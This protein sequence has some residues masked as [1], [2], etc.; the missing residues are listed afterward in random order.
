MTGT[1]SAGTP[2]N[3][4]VDWGGI[5]P[6]VYGIMRVAGSSNTHNIDFCEFTT[7][8]NVR[9]LDPYGQNVTVVV[10]ALY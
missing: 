7:G 10:F 3:L 8:N 9:V 4:T 2:L 5:I 6:I 1:A